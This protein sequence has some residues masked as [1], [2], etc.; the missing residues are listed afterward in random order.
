MEAGA[1]EE[2][3][4]M[5][6]PCEYLLPSGVVVVDCLTTVIITRYEHSMVMT[7]GHLRVTF[8]RDKKILSWEFSTRKHEE[9][10]FKAG[11]VAGS[12]LG[13][14]LSEFGL[15]FSVVLQM[16]IANDLHSMRDKI[17]QEVAKIAADPQK[18]ASLMNLVSENFQ[19]GDLFTGIGGQS[20]GH[21]FRAISSVLDGAV[22][23]HRVAG[24]SMAM[25]SAG[26]GGGGGTR[27][28]P[29][30]LDMDTRPAMKN[31]TIVPNLQDAI[32]SWKYEPQPVIDQQNHDPANAENA[33]PLM[34][35]GIFDDV[36]PAILTADG[37][38]GDRSGR[39]GHGDL[40]L[41][42]KGMG[43]N[44]EDLNQRQRG[45]SA[46]DAVA[47]AA[48]GQ[49][50]WGL[51]SSAAGDLGTGDGGAD[52]LDPNLQLIDASADASLGMQRESGTGS[53]SGGARQ[54]AP[55]GLAMFRPQGTENERHKPTTTRRI[56]GS[57]G[58]SRRGG[59][60]SSRGGGNVQGLK[61]YNGE[62]LR[63]MQRMGRGKAKREASSESAREGG[64][65]GNERG[66]FGAGSQDQ[67]G[68]VGGGKKGSR[69]EGD[70]GKDNVQSTGSSRRGGGGV[71]GDE[72]ADK[73]QKTGQ[74][75]GQK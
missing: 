11:L 75:T 61:D 50:G 10:V 55:P 32:S 47:A 25:A 19:T 12:P 54:S 58:G 59:S 45:Q 8:H 3:T 57:R 31:E 26:D 33:Q 15:P 65:G 68:G 36:N 74:N 52:E 4:L 29:V 73:R 16:M 17:G 41:P 43:V 70:G 5:E 40:N 28:F 56:R 2:R 18:L 6:D 42:G 62:N 60:G 66:D 24:G 67:N 49:G 34:F 14:A 53:R 9:F 46:I 51:G 7:D 27:G 35:P 22:V 13:P 64:G 71:V 48:S 38:A 30:N 23:D 63:A 69:A 20:N 1:K 37:D 39:R 21:A 72:R 44:V